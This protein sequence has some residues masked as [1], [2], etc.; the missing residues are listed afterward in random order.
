MKKEIYEST[1]LYIVWA[2][3]KGYPWWPAYVISILFRLLTILM[4]FIRIKNIE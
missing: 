3:V 1:K 4:N 2:K